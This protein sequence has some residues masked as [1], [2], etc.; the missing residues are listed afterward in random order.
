MSV[1]LFYFTTAQPYQNNALIMQV[2]RFQPCLTFFYRFYEEYGK[3]KE[4]FWSSSSSSAEEVV[5]TYCSTRQPWPWDRSGD[6]WECG[7]GDYRRYQRVPRSQ[8]IW[9]QQVSQPNLL[10]IRFICW[11]HAT[12]NIIDVK[13]SKYCMRL[14]HILRGQL[15]WGALAC[16][17]NVKWRCKI[18]FNS[19][20]SVLSIF[21]A[22]MWR[23]K[24]VRI[25][26]MK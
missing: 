25:W 15:S 14:S 21:T 1:Q 16:R 10:M 4:T 5:F 6:C 18:Y 12:L 26:R 11:V 22:A 7:G 19:E 13:I 24:M 9:Y 3:G 2:K 20:K 23:R 17:S 8:P